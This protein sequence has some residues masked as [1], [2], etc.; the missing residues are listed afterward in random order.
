MQPTDNDLATQFEANIRETARS[1]EKLYRQTHPSST[2]SEHEISVLTLQM[3][4]KSTTTNLRDFEEMAI[5]AYYNR[6]NPDW[7][8]ARPETYR[9]Q[10]EEDDLLRY[11]LDD[12]G[13]VLQN[14]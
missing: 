5:A 1:L 3:R 8:P 2:A 6:N 4:D 7:D 12:N 9:T 14:G 13:P 10:L 11:L